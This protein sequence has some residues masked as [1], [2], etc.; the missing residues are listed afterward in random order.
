M[1]APSFEDNSI[2]MGLDSVVSPTADKITYNTYN[3]WG[4][5]NST[6]DG[7]VATLSISQT[8]IQSLHIWMREDGALIDRII[9]TQNASYVPTSSGPAA[10]NNCPS[11]A[12]F[13]VEM[14]EFSTRKLA[15]HIELNWKT[16]WE[17]NNA[18][19][20]VEK[21][22][23]QNEWRS[24]EQ[25][26]GSGT[27]NEPQTYQ[28]IDR[29]PW[30]GANFYRLKQ[31]DLNGSFTYSEIKEVSW[32]GEAWGRLRVWPNPLEDGRLKVS[33]ESKDDQG[34]LAILDLR[35][36][37]HWAREVSLSNR[38]IHEATYDLDRLAAGIYFVRWQ[39]ANYTQTQK[40]IVK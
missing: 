36:R 31:V 20:E 11:G 33:I 2:H 6:M 14:L 37:K 19:F 40:I 17:Q 32:Q 9:L 22:V 35:G 18:Y 25:I 39:S 7:P 4:W 12:P 34:S 38:R 15:D 28:W 1:Y 8:G 30:Q 10:T 29:S 23:N 16:R 3:Q 24:M 27:S 26:G 21:S 5:T 13:P